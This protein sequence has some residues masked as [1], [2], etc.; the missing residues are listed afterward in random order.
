MTLNLRRIVT[1]TG[2]AAAFGLL[3]LVAFGMPGRAEDDPGK[4]RSTDI[5]TQL[6]GRKLAWKSLD[7]SLD[8]FGEITFMKDGRV[9]M[10][11][12]LPGLPA[13][14]GKWWF[15]KDQICTRW[16]QAREGEEKCYH[17]IDQGSGRFLTTGGNLFEIGGDPIV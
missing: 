6:V 14:E 4:M 5:E 3:F 8:V 17:L 7:G 11:T 12:N 1:I 10:T 2:A 15:D 13:D 16:G 9:V